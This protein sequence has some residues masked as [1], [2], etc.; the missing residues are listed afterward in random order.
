MTLFLVVLF[1]FLC[2]L[3]LRIFLLWILAAPYEDILALGME[4]YYNTLYFCRIMF[5]LNSAI[6]PVLY[7]MTSARFRG[8]FMAVC[9]SR[10]NRRKFDRRDIFTS[11]D[12]RSS[13]R[14]TSLHSS[15]RSHSTSI[16]RAGATAAHKQASNAISLGL[17]P[18]SIR[19][20]NKLLATVREC[21]GR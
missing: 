18:T 5:Y 9:S 13:S 4:N 3:P 7:N 1:F 17:T 10:S 2:L 19:R 20:G 6:N 11:F 15:G 21:D 16:T 14:S 12:K 8:A